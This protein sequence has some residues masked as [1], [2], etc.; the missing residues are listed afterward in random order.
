M[1][2]YG[3]PGQIGVENDLKEYIEALVAI[4]HKV[5]R[6]LANDGTLWLNLGD[7]YTS[8]GRAYRAPDKKRIM[9]TLSVVYPS[10]RPPS[11]G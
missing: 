7:A 1:R 4:L 5:K 9:A 8:G 11:Q 3:T 6:V 2:N 10:G